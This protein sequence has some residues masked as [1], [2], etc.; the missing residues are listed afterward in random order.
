MVSWALTD[1]PGSPPA[2]QRVVVVGAGMAG[3][4]AA[5]LL[6]SSG[7]AV[8]VLEARARLGGRI[9]TDSR[10]GLPIDLGASWIHAADTN[11][12]TRWAR[13]SGID[14]LHAPTGRRRFYEEGRLLRLNALARR[15]RRGLAR[16]A[17]DAARARRRARHSGHPASLG[18]VLEPLLTEPGLPL[19]DRRLLAWITALSESVEGAPAAAIDLAHWYPGE[20][21][22]LNLLPR[23]GYARLVEDAAAG[24]DVRFD[25]PVRA[26]RYGGPRVAVETPTDAL[27]ADA[28]VITVPLGALKAGQ[29][30]F[31]PPLPAPKHAA[32]ARIGYG[33]SA[34]PQGTVRAVMNKVVLRYDARFWP[35]STERLNLLPADPAAR[36]RYTN[37]ISLA[38]L[39]GVPLVMGFCSGPA[40][41]QLERDA[42]DAALVAEAAANLARLSGLARVPEPSAALV[43][44]WLSDPWARGA[45][46]YASIHSSD[47][48]RTDYQ[49]PIGDRLYFAGEGTQAR[50]YGTVQAALRS[51]EQAAA[52][53][54][55]RFTGRS[56]RLDRLP[57][58]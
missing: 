28:V 41:A 26:I 33:E 3:L 48:D 38:P 9:W 34:T 25:A 10:L 6:Q 35:D 51:G 12:L 17:F 2:A 4:V 5:R 22:G 14:L 31:E 45:Y 46:S 37:W 36:G 47:A 19:F 50:D 30:R 55:Q 7:F 16:A 56:P 29:I 18:S 40:A 58:A 15:G 24:L 49:R 32:I 13:R 8:T 43:T 27:H 52:A 42:D 11:P 21:N 57:W 1:D 44:R 39:L 20:A 54:F 23:G 53:I